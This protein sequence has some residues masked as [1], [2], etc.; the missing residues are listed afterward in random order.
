MSEPVEKRPDRGPERLQ[1]LVA[2]LRAQ[3][4]S[5]VDQL[6]GGAISLHFGAMMPGRHRERGKWI[7]TSW[8]SDLL[9]HADEH[10]LDSTQESAEDVVRALVQSVGAHVTIAR[11]EAESLQLRLILSDGVDITLSVD[12]AYDGD[13]WALS[14]PSGETAVVHRGSRWSLQADVPPRSESD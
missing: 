14:L 7:V 8:G 1:E 13:A 3:V 4:L 12:E 2:E 9:L 6:Y 5:R 10:E 11:V